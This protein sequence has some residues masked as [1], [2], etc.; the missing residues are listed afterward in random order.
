LSLGGVGD[1]RDRR[2]FLCNLPE[3]GSGELLRRLK[4]RWRTLSPRPAQRLVKIHVQTMDRLA[5]QLKMEGC[6]ITFLKGYPM[7]PIDVTARLMETHRKAM[8]VD[9]PGLRP[10]RSPET[11]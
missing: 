6:S 3:S 10:T 1:E 5:T 8:A 2:N 9:Q 4:R 11:S 7:A